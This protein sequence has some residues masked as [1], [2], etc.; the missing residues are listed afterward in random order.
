M[1]AGAP[2]TAQAAVP[3]WARNNFEVAIPGKAAASIIAIE[4]PT[5]AAWEDCGGVGEGRCPRGAG[6]TRGCRWKRL[7]LPC[8]ERKRSRSSLLPVFLSLLLWNRIAATRW[9]FV[10]DR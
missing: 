10:A 3:T 7:G 1:G 6:A 8:L 5:R 2:R 9:S 4:F